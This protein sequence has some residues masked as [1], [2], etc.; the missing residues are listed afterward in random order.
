MSQSKIGT[1]FWHL[2]EVPTV[3]HDREE[4]M[5]ADYDGNLGSRTPKEEVNRKYLHVEKSSRSLS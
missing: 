3:T 4:R 5:A 2:A 1:I